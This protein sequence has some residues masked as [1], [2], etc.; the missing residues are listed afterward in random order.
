[1]AD[2][3]AATWGNG[4]MGITGAVSAANSLVGSSAGD[5]VSSSGPTALTNGDYVVASRDWDNGVT[6]NAGALSFGRAGGTTGAVG[7]ANSVVGIATTT[8]TQVSGLGSGFAGALQGTRA[9]VV[10]PLE[11]T[12]F[13]VASGQTI[14]SPTARITQLLSA[15][16]NVT[17]QASQDITITSPITVNNPTGNGGNLTLI[18]GRSVIVNGA[19]TSDNGNFE[20]RANSNAAAGVV[21]A[22]RGAGAGS[23][24]NTATI[25]AGTGTIRLETQPGT[26]L[27]NNTRADYALGTLT[28]ATTTV[29]PFSVSLSPTA[30]ERGE[31]LTVVGGGLTG[32]TVTVGGVAATTLSVQSNQVQVQVPTGVAL[33]SQAVVLTTPSGSI[34]VG[35]VS[36]VIKTDLAVTKSVDAAT[37]SE[38]DRI[39]YTVQVGN[40]S[41]ATATGVQLTDALPAGVTLV[42]A[43]PSQGSFTQG[44]GLWS[45]GSLAPTTT[46]T[47]TLEVS[48][49]AGTAGTTITNTTSGLAA[50]T[51]LSGATSDDVGSAAITVAAVVSGGGGPPL[52]ASTPQRVIKLK[53]KDC[54]LTQADTSELPLPLLAILLGLFALRLR[55]GSLA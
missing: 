15:G 32:A 7:P 54:S 16:T 43:V 34:G 55:R 10:F 29:V 1:M 20:A 41:T 48:V 31:T 8:A 11:S 13:S 37:P 26:G 6:L 14:T 23:V 53:G 36:V 24:Q 25:D 4:A 44:S 18:A 51:F 50:T 46:A 35:S 21:D 9:A 3:G 19:I 40:K 39:N 52:G 12:T 49:D 28:A 42:S 2:A 45:V 5:Q 30:A 17:L 33:G 47:L 38:R 22:D 27:T